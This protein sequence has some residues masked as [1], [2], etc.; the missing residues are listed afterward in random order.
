VLPPSV[1]TALARAIGFAVGHAGDDR[2]A[3]VARHMR[4]A[5][6]PDATDAEVSR[7]VDD[8]FESYAHYWLDSFRLPSLSTAEVGAGFGSGG[9]DPH[10]LDGLRAGTGVILALPHLG[11][12][13]WAGRWIA[14]QGHPI[15]VVVEPLDPPE[16]F[17][18][19]TRMRSSLGMTVVALGP[20]AGAAVLRALRDNHVVCLLSDRDI[21]GGGVP[22]DFFGETTTLPAG[23]ATLSL[24]TG[25][26]I[27]PTAV[28][29][30]NE[31]DG[32][33][34]LVRPPLV[35]PSTGRRRDDVAALTQALAHELEA[36]IRRAPAQWHLLQPNW[37][38]DRGL[39]AAHPSPFH[40]GKTTSDDVKPA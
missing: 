32:H 31:R 18:W 36:L 9:Y 40:A 33:Y 4:R 2:R 38:S 5:L 21:Q 29:F 12:W 6:G 39:A 11:G 34:G 16:A 10:I 17:D 3:M 14:D 24:R 26:P 1:S 37:P 35:V 7:M 15:T 25:A 19:F 22:V 23:P 30:T 28:Y 8:V 20:G 13:E 27:L